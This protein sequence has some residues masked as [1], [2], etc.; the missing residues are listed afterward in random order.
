MLAEKVQSTLLD[1]IRVV[2]KEQK[3][4]I[5]ITPSLYVVANVGEFLKNFYLVE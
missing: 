3:I 2:D 5:W 4:V 1:Q